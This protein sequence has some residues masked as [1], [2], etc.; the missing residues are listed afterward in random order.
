MKLF[1]LFSIFIAASIPLAILA[2]ED[3]DPVVAVKKPFGQHADKNRIPSGVP[4]IL[5]HGGPILPGKVPVYVIYYGNFGTPETVNTQSIVNDFLGGLSGQ[6]QYQVNSTY[7]DVQT[8]N[9]AST[10][11]NSVAGTLDFSKGNIFLDSGSQGSQVNS[12]GVIKILQYAF[13]HSFPVTDGGVYFVI[14]A[15]DVKVPGFCTSFCAYHSTSASIVAGHTIRYALVPDPSQ[16]CTVCDGNFALGDSA[17]PNGDAGAD[18]MVDS[19]FHELSETVT[20]PDLNAWYT[21][22]GEE[23]GDLCNY[24]YG[25]TSTDS[26]GIHYNATWGRRNYLIQLIWKN[27][28]V[29]QACAAAP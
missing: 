11:A 26:N 17:T 2:G 13:Q 9:C 23:N 7:C 10:T 16:R 24:N 29:P 3:A 15:P 28:P 4:Q 18:E 6:P 5:Y 14:T 12:G 25:T 8:V 21:S 20:D 19:M 22:N 1:I 27:G